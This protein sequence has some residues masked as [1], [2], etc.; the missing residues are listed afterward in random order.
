[1]DVNLATYRNYYTKKTVLSLHDGERHVVSRTHRDIIDV[2]CLLRQDVA[3]GDIK[4]RLRAKLETKHVNEDELLEN[5]IDLAASLM[6]MC[7][8]GISSHGFSVSTEIQWKTDF[9]KIFPC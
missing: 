3:K 2:V 4:Q 9:L 7:D 8:C 1:M 6:L 5:S